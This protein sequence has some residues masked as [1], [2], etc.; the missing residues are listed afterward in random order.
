MGI[1]AY[2]DD[3]VEHTTLLLITHEQSIVIKV[4]WTRTTSN[5]PHAYRYEYTYWKM[6]V[7]LNHS[8]GMRLNL[9]IRKSAHLHSYILSYKAFG[10]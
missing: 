5:N 7:T 6:S 2:D 8:N 4:I 1:H 10:S 9:S 3:R